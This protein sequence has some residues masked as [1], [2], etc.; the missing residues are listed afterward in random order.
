MKAF[1]SFWNLLDLFAVFPP[2]LEWVLLCLHYSTFSALLARFDFRWFKILRW[3]LPPLRC[4]SSEMHTWG[5]GALCAH[6]HNILQSCL[7]QV[8]LGEGQA[9]GWILYTRHLHVVATWRL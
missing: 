6:V 8:L 9:R 5:L 7:S 4:V 2:L 3:G 1:L